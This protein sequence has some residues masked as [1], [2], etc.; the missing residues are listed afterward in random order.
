MKKIV[1]M[2]MAAALLGALALPAFA[3]D[4]PADQTV[5]DKN[6]TE[7]W[8]NGEAKADA[9]LISVVMPTAINFQIATKD[10][11]GTKVLDDSDPTTGGVVSG[12]GKFTNN[13]NR[14][15]T[16]TLAEVGDAAV[17]AS[18]GFLNVV[19]VYLAPAGMVRGDVLGKAEYQLQTSTKDRELGT[20]GLG[21]TL[22]L[23]IFAQDNTADNTSLPDGS[24]QLRTVMKVSAAS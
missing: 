20:M 11:A 16:L 24:Y 12:T 19:E 18:A 22:S 7:V 17:T 13:S 9:E 3:A 1:S 15:V 21:G 23:K 10:N 4:A 14:S 5:T 6:G 8:L 2:L